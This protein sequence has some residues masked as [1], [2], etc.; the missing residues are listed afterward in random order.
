MIALLFPGQGVQKVGMLSPFVNAFPCAKQTLEEIEEATSFKI[1]SLT[2]TGSLEE[3]SRTENAQ[4]AIFTAS[5]LC[6]TILKHEYG[7]DLKT[8][9]KY[10]AGHSLGE[11]T[12]LCASDVFSLR[13][14]SRLVRKRGELMASACK[15]P[16][17]Y[18]MSAVLNSTLEDVESII[19]EYKNGN[20]VCVI[21]N[22]NSKTQVVLSGH[23]GAVRTAIEKL[24]K[25][26]SWVK[27]IDLNTSGAF[28]SP[29]MGSVAIML[30]EYLATMSVSFSEFSVPVISNVTATPI[31]SKN[32]VCNE[33]ISQMISRVR[34]RETIELIMGD[35]EIERTV[36]IAPGRVLANMIKR[37]YK[38]RTITNLD[39]INQIEKFMEG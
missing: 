18:L 8:Q 31:T 23:V 27:T 2:E 3:L 20:E 21:A 5:M 28:H 1:F 16:R 36:E 34:W 30:D 10:L 32:D 33:L 35:N 4:L 19:S 12:A 6:L 37:D 14:A 24:T 15:N 29:I 39:T 11:Y 25:K 38:E 17:D 26:F 13:D 9:C 7:F 22:D